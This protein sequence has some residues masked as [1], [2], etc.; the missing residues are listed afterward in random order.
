MFAQT[1]A[2]MGLP[3]FNSMKQKGSSERAV[4]VMEATNQ[5]QGIDHTQRLALLVADTVALLDRLGTL[6]AERREDAARTEKQQRKALLELL[7]VVD[8]FNDV[9]DALATLKDLVPAEQQ[10]PFSRLRIVGKQLNRWLSD[11][12]VEPYEAEGA[13][14]PALHV[15]VATVLDASRS[16]GAI[17]R[18][19]RCGYRWE[20]AVLRVAQVVV[21]TDDPALV[22]I[23]DDEER[24]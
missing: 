16:P 5:W 6:E 21:A 8:S 11:Q 13:F 17:I 3:S 24:G 2:P 14:D 18:Q 9:A 1:T 20:D 10:R 22:T 12:G 4:A 19:T 23:S 7:V 15:I